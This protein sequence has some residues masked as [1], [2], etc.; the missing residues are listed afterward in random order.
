MKTY[1]PIFLFLICMKACP[2]ESGPQAGTVTD[3]VEV[4]GAAGETYALYLPGRYTEQRAFP[5]VFVFDPAARGKT[6][7][8]PFIPAA[9]KYDYILI[10]SN[11]TRN[12][13]YEVNFKVAERLFTHSLN[14]YSIMPRRI[15]TAG[16]SGGARLAATIAIL[17]GAIE[18]VIGCGAGF[19]GFPYLPS[20]R[21]H[22]SYAGLVG[23]LDMNYAEVT[24]LPQWLEATGIPVEIFTFEGGHSWP[25]AEDLL[26]AFDWL[27]LEAM[28]KGMI[29]KDEA[30]ILRAFSENY[31]RTRSHESN[32]DLYTSVRK[33]EQIL[34]NYGPFLELDTLRLRVDS[35]KEIK[36]Y[37]KEERAYMLA[38]QLED[39]LSAQ[40]QK[41][42][43]RELEQAGTTDEFKWWQR[44]LRV[45]RENFLQ[46]E[47]PERKH[48]GERLRSQLLAITVETFD[49]QVA[50]GQPE[51]ALY[52]A[53][54]FGQI[55]P[56]NAY[57]HFKFAKGFARLN[58]PDPATEHL[59]RALECGWDDKGAL[60]KGSELRPL[61]Q[62][63]PVKNL[64]EKL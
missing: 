45:L 36:A 13:P 1:W 37:K 44:Q 29:P 38:R 27:Q 25:P 11:N 50:G 28:K 39:T 63:E 31:R 20:A 8:T 41:R 53:G 26:R 48:I 33:Y 51:K 12:G 55:D 2:Q 3:S 16:F 30:E 57:I 15:Y 47:Q 23:H 42:F 17:S 52:C 61:L 46:S 34:R 19:A 10:G 18:G 62:K 24:G 6:A 32:T 22:Y 5:V 59:I 43:Y 14:A 49:A 58:M 35:L 7:I 56:E 64:L 60:E 21:D 54:L 4:S 40:Y 9:E